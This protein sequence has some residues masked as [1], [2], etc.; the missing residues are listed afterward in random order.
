MTGA[1][2]DH[3]TP[4]SPLS[5]D[6]V[7]LLKRGDV[8]MPEPDRLGTVFDH[9]VPVIFVR[10][11]DLADSIRVQAPRWGPHN[12]F[13]ADRFTFIGRPDPAIE[14][15]RWLPDPRYPCYYVSDQ[16]RMIGRTGR[17]LNPSG[18]YLHVKKSTLPRCNIYVHEAVAAAFI[19][20]RPDGQYVRHLDGDRT[21]NRLS[22]IA[23][24][25]PA[26]NI[27]DAREHG[28]MSRGE[29]HTKSILTEAQVREIRAAGKT[30]RNDLAAR[31]GVHRVT[32]EKIIGGRSWKHV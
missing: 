20:P 1:A 14:G 10:A 28:T 25:T 5:A 30:N 26:E 21:N 27:S 31:Y 32:I 8:L 29:A 11:S 4:G 13:S 7:G 17:I 6:D 18:R 22:N 12:W 9:G 24:G 16:G 23:Y 3:P 2:T 19:G 15:E